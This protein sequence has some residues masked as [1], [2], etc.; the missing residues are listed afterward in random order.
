M[1]DPATAAFNAQSPW[2]RCSSVCNYLQVHMEPQA[3]AVQDCD[4]DVSAIM[5]HDM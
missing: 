2:M 3:D 4:A 5:M 1:R